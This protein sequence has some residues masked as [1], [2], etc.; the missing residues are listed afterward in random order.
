MP[1]KG[2]SNQSLAGVRRLQTVSL[3]RGVLAVSLTFERRALSQS[4]PVPGAVTL[5]HSAK[6]IHFERVIAYDRHRAETA[7]L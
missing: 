3:W 1:A 4:R 7:R 5:P 2:A 6:H